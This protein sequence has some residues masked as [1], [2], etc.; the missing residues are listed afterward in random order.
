MVSSAPAID[1]HLSLI[2]SLMY[3]AAAVDSVNANL[4][5]IQC[6]DSCRFGPV[7]KLNTLQK[8]KDITTQCCGGTLLACKLLVKGLVIT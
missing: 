4:G 2:S 8:R 5:V 7:A 6:F 1:I 3:G